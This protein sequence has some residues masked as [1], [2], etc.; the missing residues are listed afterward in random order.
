M[1]ERTEPAEDPAT[2]THVYTMK[3]I[4]D[5][6]IAQCQ[7]NAREAAMLDKYIMHILSLRAAAHT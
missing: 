6:G 1:Q 7:L 5:G 4:A 2:P 3:S